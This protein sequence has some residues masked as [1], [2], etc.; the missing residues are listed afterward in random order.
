MFF[1]LIEIRRS[2]EVRISKHIGDINICLSLIIFLKM[3][4]F[5]LVLSDII[6]RQFANFY[7]C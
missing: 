4:L 3:Y 1:K 6:T 5:I 2:I 7:K